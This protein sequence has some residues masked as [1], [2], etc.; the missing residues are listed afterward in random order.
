M[1]DFDGEEEARPDY[2]CPYCYE[3]FDIASLC[4]HLEAEHSYESKS[5]VSSSLDPRAFFIY[6]F[7]FLGFL[8]IHFICLIV[9]IHLLQIK[10]CLLWSVF[11]K[12]NDVFF[13]EFSYFSSI[14]VIS[15]HGNV[16]WVSEKS[17]VFSFSRVNVWLNL[18]KWPSLV[19][20]LF[21]F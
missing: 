16:R 15:I 6:G 20:S 4:S 1:E 13:F 21:E 5:T 10:S 8:C 11:A 12:K 18:R 9:F 14:L 2:P 19:P 3:E 17:W 7:P